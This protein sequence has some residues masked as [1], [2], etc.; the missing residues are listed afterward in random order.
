MLIDFQTALSSFCYDFSIEK[1]GSKA[2]VIGY[3]DKLRLSAYTKQASKG[4]FDP[5]HCPEVG[6]LDRI[7]NDRREAWRGL[8]DMPR[9]KAM[10]ELV[11]LVD[12]LSPLFRP[13]LEAHQA[14]RLEQERIRLVLT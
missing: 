1:D 8:G 13:Y 14:S 5:A 2:V 9:D 7:G 4:A 12:R 10:S 3:E 6:F 11:Q